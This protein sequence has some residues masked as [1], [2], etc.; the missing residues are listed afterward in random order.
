MLLAGRRESVG[1]KRVRRVVEVET[2]A[3][4]GGIWEDATCG[5]LRFR[6]RNGFLWA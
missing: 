5:I 2:L 6:K 1:W 3:C 4:G